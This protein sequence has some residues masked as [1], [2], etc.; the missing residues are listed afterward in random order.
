MDGR[1]DG[2]T[3]K[4][5]HRGAPLLTMC[6]IDHHVQNKNCYRIGESLN[7]Y[8]HP[9]FVTFIWTDSRGGSPIMKN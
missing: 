7:L 4:M 3:E 9:D 2:R 6:I 8:N 5:S 1:L